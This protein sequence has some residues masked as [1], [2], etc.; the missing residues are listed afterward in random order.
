MFALYSEQNALSTKNDAPSETDTITEEL[1]K[2]KEE[3]VKLEEQ[4]NNI[5]KEIETKRESCD[6]ETEKLKEELEA[7]EEKEGENKK[8]MVKI[9]KLTQEEEA[10]QTKLEKKLNEIVEVLSI[11]EN[12]YEI[13]SSDLKMLEFRRE[14]GTAFKCN[15]ISTA[16]K[17]EFDEGLATR[18][19]SLATRFKPKD[20]K[21]NKKM[22]LKNLKSEMQIQN[23]LKEKLLLSIKTLNLELDIVKEECSENLSKI[24]SLIDDTNKIILSSSYN[25]KAMEYNLKSV[26]EFTETLK[27]QIKTSRGLLVDLQQKINDMKI[28]VATYNDDKVCYDYI[29]KSTA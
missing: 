20:A 24:K 2:I 13:I 6:Q 14:N 4:K 5:S 17:E 15:D 25:V 9:M 22:K 21:L 7:L 11:F 28:A 10:E 3:I 1:E 19:S 26:Q 8:E 18:S 23:V 29:M 16:L 27:E 12:Q